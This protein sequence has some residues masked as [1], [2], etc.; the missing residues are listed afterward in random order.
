MSESFHYAI[1]IITIMIMVIPPPTPT[2]IL[3]SGETVTLNECS[4]DFIEKKMVSIE[5]FVNKFWSVS[6]RMIIFC[7][8]EIKTN[9]VFH[10]KMRN[11]QKFLFT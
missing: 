2:L 7:K 1:T 3:F 4:N 5:S 6:F 10:I 11:K 8:L 9:H